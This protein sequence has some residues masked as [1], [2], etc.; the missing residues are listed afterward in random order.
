MLRVDFCQSDHVLNSF[1]MRWSLKREAFLGKRWRMNLVWLLEFKTWLSY[2]RHCAK[3]LQLIM[4]RFVMIICQN[5]KIFNF[6]VLLFKTVG[7]CVSEMSG[8]KLFLSRWH[9]EIPKF[10][11]FE[12]IWHWNPYE[13]H[14]IRWTHALQIEIVCLKVFVLSGPVYCKYGCYF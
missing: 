12:I 10:V 1:L 4:N 6:V 5:S 3:R 14:W 11:S 8:S 13:K 7:R 9:S 2:P